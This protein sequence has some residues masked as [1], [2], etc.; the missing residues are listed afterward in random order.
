MLLLLL[1][2]P[3][4][5]HSLP[6]DPTSAALFLLFWSAGQAWP[7]Y[8]SLIGALISAM[9]ARGSSWL[10]MKWIW[11]GLWLRAKHL[12]RPGE[13]IEGEGGGWNWT[14]WRF[15]RTVCDFWFAAL[16]THVW[17]KRIEP[18]FFFFTTFMKPPQPTRTL[19]A[20]LSFTKSISC[21]HRNNF[22]ETHLW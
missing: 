15:D 6:P 14:D 17:W 8:N 4:L 18:G 12:L 13:G 2:H 7:A 16:E 19:V 10:Q 9:S 22:N 21:W 1:I 5:H 3:V 20:N 11:F